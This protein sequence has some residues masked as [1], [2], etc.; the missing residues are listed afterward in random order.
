MLKTIQELAEQITESNGVSRFSEEDVA[1][2]PT[3][4]QLIEAM[5]KSAIEVL[6]RNASLREARRFLLETAPTATTG[7]D[8][9]ENTRHIV[10]GLDKTIK[11]HQVLASFFTAQ[12]HILK[13]IQT[14]PAE[15]ACTALLST[16]RPNTKDEASYSIPLQNT[17]I[18]VSPLLWGRYLPQN[19]CTH[20]ELGPSLLQP[21]VKVPDCV[22]A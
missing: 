9:S 3:L 16:L 7:S 15:Q 21:D 11:D 5:N 19:V 13:G 12:I 17:N 8:D 22:P 2:L 6:A 4:T 20:Y 1:A 10:F 18:R 14:E